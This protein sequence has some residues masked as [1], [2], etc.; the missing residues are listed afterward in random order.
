MDRSAVRVSTISRLLPEIVDE[1]L[2]DPEI[3][4]GIT[5]AALD[6]DALRQRTLAARSEVLAPADAYLDRVVD[7]EIGRPGDSDDKDEP[8]HSLGDTIGGLVVLLALGVPATWVLIASWSDLPWWGIALLAVP[9]IVSLLGALGLLL[10]V[11]DRLDS[12]PG[13]RTGTISDP[14]ARW[15]QVCRDD[16]VLPFVRRIVNENLAPLARTSLTV[17]IEDAPGL[18]GDRESS[19]AVRTSSV[20][21]FMEATRRLP[22]GAIGL[23]GPRGVGKTSLIEFFAGRGDELTGPDGRRTMMV[24]VSAPVEYEPRDFVLHLFASVCRTVLRERPGRVAQGASAVRGRLRRLI[25]SLAAAVVA[26]VLVVGVDATREPRQVLDEVRAVNLWLVPAALLTLLFAL[27]LI[28]WVW[29]GLRALRRN[30]ESRVVALARRHLENIHYLQTHTSGWSGKLTLPLQS[31]ASWTRQTQRERRPQT[32]PEV[33]A[34]LCEFLATLA[35]EI[36]TTPA[37]IVAVDELDKIQSADRAQQFVNEIKSV[38][39][40]PGTQFLVSV[41]EDALASFE[42]RG[43][44]VR[45]AFDSAFHEIVRVDYMTL[46]DTGT[47]LDSRVIGLPDPFT[48]LVHCMSGGLPRDVVRT[49]R[50]M[51]ALTRSDQDALTLDQVCATL[52]GD[53]LERK[54]HAFQLACRDIGDSPEV[55]E[56]IRSLRQLPGEAPKL[57]RLVRE[58]PRDG[59]LAV[60]SRQAAAYVYYSATLLEV[61]TRDRIDEHDPATFDGLARARQSL[62]VHPRLAWLQ[63]DEFRSAWGLDLVPVD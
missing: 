17:T 58:L 36:G 39:G 12:S 25:L 40:A 46:A 41:S 26:A 60:L 13:T 23:A 62:A 49:A 59:E 50:T 11:F 5:R 38:F 24:T 30:R 37:I 54:S 43:L 33:V 55:T 51:V 63:V 8:S 3:T 1:V 42:R 34:A 18:H 47:L 48:W 22:T 2:A 27:D 15:R 6:P 9:I 29:S 20:A 10:E 4:L 32:Y 57:L 16:G 44:P 35:E 7:A 19:Y 31:E 14:L 56:F 52:V 53:E 28:G 61:F 21:M 45:D